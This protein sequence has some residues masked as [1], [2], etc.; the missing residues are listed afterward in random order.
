MNQPATETPVENFI[1]IPPEQALADEVARLQVELAEMKDK[2][3]RALAEAEN[4]RK[5]TERQREDAVKYAITGFARDL[6][7]VSDNLSRAMQSAPT[8]EDNPFVTGIQ[9]TEKE[10]LSV[11]ERHG[12]RRIDPAKGEKFDHNRHQAMVEIPATD[13]TPGSIAQVIQTG[14]VLHDRLLRPALVAVAK[15]ADEK[16]DTSV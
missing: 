3:L 8:G 9:M 14:Y 1:E 5:I 12:I 15:A 2:A 13:V 11:F 10:L 4:T 7:N 6:L 16:I